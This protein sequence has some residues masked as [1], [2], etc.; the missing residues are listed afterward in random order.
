V[1]PPDPTDEQLLDQVARLHGLPRQVLDS[2]ELMRL[3]LPAL[4]ADAVLYTRY[5]YHPE[6]PLPCD[7]RAYGGCDD[8]NV[9]THH[10]ERWAEQTTGS[11][12]LRQFPGGHFYLQTDLPRFLNALSEDL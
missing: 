7:I 8:P 2:P 12:A 10:L 11:F 4:R 6:P 9:T 3:V 5:V 1:P